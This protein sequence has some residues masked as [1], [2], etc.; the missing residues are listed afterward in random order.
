MTHNLRDTFSDTQ[1]WVFDLDHTL[2]PPDVPLFAQMEVRM[3]DYMCRILHLDRD[4]A[5]ALRADYWR[6][7]GTTLAG[8]MAEHQI[9]PDPFL[10]DVHQ[11]DFSVVPQSP[12]LRDLITRLDNRKIIYTN[13]TAPYAKDVTTARGIA[14][15]LMQSTASSTRI[16]IPSPTALLL[17]R[18]SHSTGSTE[19]KRSCSRTTPVTLR[20]RRKWGLPQY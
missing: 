12:T 11:L 5:N 2:Y 10:W 6:D 8:L 7:H 19:R 14:G 18:F 20:S 1:T 15:C 13:G 4:T 17:K 9:D 16:T 3:V